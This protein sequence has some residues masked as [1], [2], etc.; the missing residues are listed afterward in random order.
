MIVVELVGGLG[1]QM[2]QY[3][4]ARTLADRLGTDLGLDLR[5]FSVPDARPYHLGRFNIRATAIPARELLGVHGVR[6]IRRRLTT[7]ALEHLRLFARRPRP[8]FD[9]ATRIVHQGPTYSDALERAT[10]HSWLSGYWQS[11]QY[12]CEAT[13]AVRADLTLRSLSPGSA[14]IAAR[15]ASMRYPVAV[16]VRRGDYAHVASTR[17]RHGLCSES[18]Y[19]SAIAHVR[20]RVLCAEAIFFSD[21]PDWVGDHLG[22]EAALVVTDN[23]DRPEEDLHLMTCCRSHVIANSSFSWWGAWLARSDEVIAPRAW[24]QA[25][26]LDGRDIVPSRWV[27][28]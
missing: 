19:R 14:A 21:E 17:A 24:Y 23:A 7:G 2:F 3:A 10:D 6:S 13:D 15:L 20:R 28:L 11:E 18:Y 16:H 27:R 1:N 8:R 22:S 25:P 4:A 5:P 9:R 26:G 12:F